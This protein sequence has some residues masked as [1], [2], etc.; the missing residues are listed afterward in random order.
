MKGAEDDDEEEEE[1]EHD[2]DA[3]SAPYDDDDEEDDDDDE[4]EE[5]DDAVLEEDDADPVFSSHLNRV[6]GS[7][8]ARLVTTTEYASFIRWQVQRIIDGTQNSSVFVDF[9]LLFAEEL[10]VLRNF[11]L[12]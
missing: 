1:E 2:N 6:V 5:D 12:S 7:L 9:A 8:F 10:L 4:D 11:F 3:L